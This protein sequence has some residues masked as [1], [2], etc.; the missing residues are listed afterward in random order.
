MGMTGMAFYIKIMHIYHGYLDLLGINQS[1]SLLSI[2]LLWP[3]VWQFLSSVD[4]WSSFSTYVSFSEK[5]IFLTH[6]HTHVCVRIWGVR[7]WEMLV[8]C[9]ILQKHILENHFHHMTDL[10]RIKTIFRELDVTKMAT[11]NFNFQGVSPVQI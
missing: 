6:W 3:L 4:F 7:V 9:K 11:F 10:L 2:Y 5:L 8:V 1:I